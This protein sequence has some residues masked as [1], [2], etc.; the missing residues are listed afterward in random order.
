MLGW[1]ND[2]INMNV[3]Q[4]A[5]QSIL[6]KR[7]RKKRE[8]IHTVSGNNSMF[9]TFVY[10]ANGGKERKDL[11][12][13]LQIHKRIASGNAWFI[14]GDMN[15]TLNP[16]KHS[17][18]SSNM[19]SDM[20][21]FKE[22]VNSIEVEDLASSGLFFTWTKNLFKV[23]ASDNTRVLKKLD[24]IIGNEEFIDKYP[25][26][27]TVFL[28]YLISDHSPNV[29]II[30][31]AIKNKKEAY[32][33]AKFLRL[34]KKNLSLLVI[35]LWD[36]AEYEGC[37]M[38]KTVKKLKN[39]KS[40]LKKLTW[41]DG[42]VF[43]RNYVKAIKDEEKLMYQK[44]KIK[45]LSFGDRNN[46][47]FHK[48][49]KSRMNKSRI[50]YVRDNKGNMFQGNDVNDQFCENI[51]KIFL[52]KQL[53]LRIASLTN[54]SNPRRRSLGKSFHFW[55]KLTH[56]CF[57]DDLLMFCHGDKRS[58]S[59]IKEAIE[60]FG[61][62]SCLL[63]NYNKSTIIFGSMKL[64]DQQEIL[65]CVPFKVDK[66]PVKYLGVPLTSKRLSVNNC[67][68][69]LDK[70]K[71]K[72][73]NWKNK[74]LS[75]AGRLQLIAS[76]LESIHVYRDSV[77]ILPKTVIKDINKLLKNFLWS[78]G[79]LSKGKA[80]VNT[81][82]L[83][84]R[85]IWAIDEESNDCW[86][87]K[88]I[89]KMRNEAREFIVM[90]IGNGGKASII[91]DNWCGAGI[92]QSFITNRDLYNA[93]R[94]TVFKDERRTMEDLFD[95]FNEIIKMRLMTLK[96]K[97]SQAVMNLSDWPWEGSDSLFWDSERS[98][99]IFNEDVAVDCVMEQMDGKCSYYRL[100]RNW[101]I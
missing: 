81:V 91:Y 11:W 74:C 29:L 95:S 54:F 82:K 43:D 39:L 17:A 1:N 24:I 3:V 50:N 16:N 84:C 18:G 99:A 47:F 27:H 36:K 8:E 53:M 101:V 68:S 44:A 57:A 67:K 70:I 87:W 30:P 13:D 80:K 41:K 4:R 42:N 34:T 56:V 90:K 12:K 35:K 6:V 38:F 93:R 76:V 59:V 60:E 5:K 71:S 46:A 45:W 83:K 92:L 79:E 40:D 52:E 61:D 62:I 66:L 37:Q 23:K 98:N 73:L 97:K 78:Q 26:A 69:L 72:V 55:I 7:R 100:N 94:N 10:V 21:D 75:Y 2:K 14:M 49:L 77:F 32:K 22:C 25:Q 31:K 19:T 20:Y 88:N 58:V 86:G 64:E 63:P 51:F 15:V 48:V 89:L 9:C 85:S 65:E 96:A 28:P 33:L